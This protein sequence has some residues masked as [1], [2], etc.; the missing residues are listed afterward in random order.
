MHPYIH[1]YTIIISSQK[2]GDVLVWMGDGI[3][4]N[5]QSNTVN[6][7]ARYDVKKTNQNYIL[8][9]KKV[10]L[11]DAIQYKCALA[12]GASH[13]A[14]LVVMSKYSL[15]FFLRLLTFPESI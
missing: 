3:I 9:I 5:S 8:L 2:K 1:S 10:I 4:W 15:L 6:N 7:K 13:S 12:S 11:K 14:N